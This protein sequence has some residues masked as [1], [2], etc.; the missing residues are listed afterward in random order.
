MLYLALRYIYGRTISKY[1]TIIKGDEMFIDAN[2][3][4]LIA[5]NSTL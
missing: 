2:I 3:P 4:Q 5:D 1:G